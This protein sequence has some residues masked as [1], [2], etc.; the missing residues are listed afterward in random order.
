MNS[1]VVKVFTVPFSHLGTGHKLL[2]VRGWGQVG[3]GVTT[4]WE[5]LGFETFCA[6]LKTG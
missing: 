5:N 2:G 4:K 3:G 6:P 1:I